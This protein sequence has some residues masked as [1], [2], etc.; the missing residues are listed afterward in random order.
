M[1]TNLP[2]PFRG[3]V[4]CCPEVVLGGLFHL[5]L[6]LRV[7]WPGPA[8]LQGSWLGAP[9]RPTPR[10]W[11]RQCHSPRP[12]PFLQGSSSN[13]FAPST[14]A[15]QTEQCGL[16]DLRSCQAPSP[17]PTVFPLTQ[18]P[19]SYRDASGAGARAGSARAVFSPS[20]VSTRGSPPR[21]MWLG[22]HSCQQ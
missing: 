4:A 10:F 18:H 6:P 16:W 13:P 14:P 22:P 2:T 3:P 12:R 17:A 8:Q 19:A 21:L 20:P 15:P 1:D 11:P 5:G 9:P 7:G